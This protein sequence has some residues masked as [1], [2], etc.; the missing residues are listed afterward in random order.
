ML[1]FYP[2]ILF[3]AYQVY[4]HSG[5]ATF[6][7]QTAVQYLDFTTQSELAW[8]SFLEALSLNLYEGASQIRDEVTLASEQANSALHSATHSSVLFAVICLVYFIYLSFIKKVPGK[9]LMLHTIVVAFICLMI[10]ISTTLLN[11]IAFREIP[12]IGTVV[13]KFE[14]KTI[15]SVLETLW[16]H[17]KYFIMSLI[18]LFSILVPLSK[19]LISSFLI[20]NTG[21]RH[22]NKLLGIVNAIGKWSMTD[23]FV[24]AVLLAFFT[25]NIDKTTHAW[26]GHGLYFFA[27]Y[28]ILS[29]VI[30]HFIS[31]RQ[32][33]S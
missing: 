20:L 12:V 26:L 5:Q 6:H 24:V 27:V 28:S 8:K 32:T 16:L 1:I 18:I 10:G 11:L 29:I 19:L 31:H 4:Y 22:N 15:V 14:S 2:L 23:V 3:L 30:S 13:F 7:Y 17:G 25:I 9:S 33:N 21:S